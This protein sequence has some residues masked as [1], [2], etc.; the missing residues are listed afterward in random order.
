MEAKN[1]IVV[2]NVKN[3]NKEKCIKLTE[4]RNKCF[5]KNEALKASLEK[6]IADNI[7]EEQ[8][9]FLKKSLRKIGGYRVPIN[10]NGNGD[11][12]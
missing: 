12:L 8:V 7:G 5:E 11:V 9:E 2:M 4:F 10:E 3:N 6:K 1:L